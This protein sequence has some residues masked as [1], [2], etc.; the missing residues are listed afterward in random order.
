MEKE[1]RPEK[2][3]R[4]HY[5]IVFLWAKYL[6]AILLAAPKA[7]SQQV[8]SWAGCNA[9]GREGKLNEGSAEKKNLSDP[10]RHHSRVRKQ[11]LFALQSLR[12]L[13]WQSCSRW[14]CS[15][16]CWR[17]R[18]KSWRSWSGKEVNGEK[19]CCRNILFSFWSLSAPEARKDPYT[20]EKPRRR[21]KYGQGSSGLWSTSSDQSRGVSE[22]NKG[23]QCSAGLCV[24]L[25]H[26]AVG[27]MGWSAGYKHP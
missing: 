17:S 21:G 15:W 13:A 5:P 24:S 3:V 4:V 1:A 27:W 23:K 14:S 16:S 20:P 6:K 26:L 9:E 8:G 7:G 10:K 22:M 19:S 12:Q 18:R 25:G 11:P 2:D